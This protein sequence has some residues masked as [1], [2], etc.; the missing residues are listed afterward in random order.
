MNVT[1][2]DGLRSRDLDIQIRTNRISVA[3]RGRDPIVE[4]TL[5]KTIKPDDSLWTKGMHLERVGEG[6]RGGGAKCTGRME[7]G[8]GAEGWKNEGSGGGGSDTREGEDGSS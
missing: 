5:Y 7:R 3:V 8:R 2:P 6:W 4:G 1:I